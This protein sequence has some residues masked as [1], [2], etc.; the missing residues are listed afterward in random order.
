MCCDESCRQRY[1]LVLWGGDSNDSSCRRALTV[2][3]LLCVLLGGIVAASRTDEDLQC[4]SGC[5]EERCLAEGGSTHPCLCRDEGVC[6]EREFEPGSPGAVGLWFAIVG[7]VGLMVQCCVACCCMRNEPVAVPVQQRPGDGAM[8][9][10]MAAPGPAKGVYA[11]PR[12]QYPQQQYAPQQYAPQQ[13]STEQPQEAYGTAPPPQYYGSGAGGGAVP[14]ES[15]GG[16]GGG[17]SNYTYA[18]PPREL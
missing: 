16:G 14:P 10:A 11:V 17:N 7:V 12:Q 1:K 6:S 2:G 4:P 8:V 15:G 9:V 5:T 3:L 18:A 13:Y